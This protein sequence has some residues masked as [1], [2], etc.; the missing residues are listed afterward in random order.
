MLSHVPFRP[1]SM[2]YTRTPQKLTHY[3]IIP[4][5]IAFSSTD[6]VGFNQRH[7][8]CLFFSATEQ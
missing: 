2:R 8:I 5:T 3:P 6:V 7:L 1:L 4:I